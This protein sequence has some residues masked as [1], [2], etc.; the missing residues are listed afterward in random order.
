LELE[1]Q[2]GDKFIAP[3]IPL[4]LVK[5][6]LSQKQQAQT[7]ILKNDFF[8]PYGGLGRRWLSN[9]KSFWLYPPYSTKHQYTNRKTRPTPLLLLDSE[10][11][12]LSFHAPVS[13]LQK[14]IL[15][16]NSPLGILAEP[17]R[18]LL[19]YSLP[20]GNRWMA[21][22]LPHQVALFHAPPSR[23]WQNSDSLTTECQLAPSDKLYLHLY[24]ASM[25]LNKEV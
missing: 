15:Y 19:L 3:I 12:R 14:Q 4:R 8:L 25:R 18:K 16:S 20:G 9:R 13:A 6:P 5:K 22:Q 7:Q 24:L 2:H 10:Q 17:K 23:T 1:R 11:V 21:F